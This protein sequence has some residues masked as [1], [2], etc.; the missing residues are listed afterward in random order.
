MSA[1]LTSHDALTAHLRFVADHSPYYR[2]LWNDAMAN[3]AG[4]PLTALPLT[5]LDTYWAANTPTDNQVLTGPQ[6]EGPVFKSGGTTG[7]PKFSFFSNQ[8]W[9]QL[10]DAFGKGMRRGGLKPGERVAN[11]FYGGQ[12]YASFLFIGRAV[13][14]AGVGIQYPLSGSAPASEIIKTLQQFEIDTLAGVPTSLLTLLPEFAA[15]QPGS[16]RLRRFLYGGEAMFPDQIEALH[17]VLPG[18]AVQSVGIA[19]VDYG[20][21]GWSEAGSEPGVHRSFDDSTVLEILDDQGRPIDEPGVSGEIYVSNFRRRLMPVIRYP[22]GDRGTWIDPPGTAARRFRVLGR[23]NNC[24]RIGPVSLYVEDIR[25][26]LGSISKTPDFINFQ[27]VVDHV[28]QRDRCTLRIAVAEPDQVPAT[29]SDAIRNAL[30]EQRPMLAE[31]AGK[32]VIHPLEVEWLRPDALTIN[33]RTGKM[34]R[35]VDIRMEA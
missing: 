20:E 17:R 24:A 14:Q 13:E 25:T 10:C 5:E 31:L 3:R 26:V 19:G 22:V 30:A 27:L 6:L 4:T 15:T 35:V 1:Q 34:L 12:L 32:G 16:I 21:L 11:M 7:N 9:L 29:L 28:Q 2:R 18:C 23:S 8:D 33:P